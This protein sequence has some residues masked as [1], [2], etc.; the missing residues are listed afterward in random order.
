MTESIIKPGDIVCIK[1]HLKFPMTVENVYDGEAT[2]VW[3]HPTNHEF[4]RQKFYV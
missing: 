2:C 4:Q 1:S 3:F